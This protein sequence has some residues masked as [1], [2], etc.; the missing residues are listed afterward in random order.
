MGLLFGTWNLELGI[1][2][3]INTTVNLVV[4]IEEINQL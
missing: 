1:W 3:L 4:G 2:N